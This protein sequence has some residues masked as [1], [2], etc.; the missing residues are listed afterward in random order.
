MW[1]YFT[2]NN[3]R[4]D[5]DALDQMFKIIKKKYISKLK[6]LQKRLAKTLTKEKFILKRP[7]CR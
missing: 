7:Q 5:L 3:T 1:K 4:F 6:W 2:V